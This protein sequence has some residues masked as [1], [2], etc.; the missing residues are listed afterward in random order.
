MVFLPCQSSIHVHVLVVFLRI[1]PAVT[2]LNLYPTYPTADL[3]IPPTVDSMGKPIRSDV[4][5]WGLS[6]RTWNPGFTTPKD[7]VIFL[8]SSMTP[9]FEYLGVWSQLVG[10]TE[11]FLPVSWAGWVTSWPSFFVS[12][13]LRILYQIFQWNMT[14]SWTMMRPDLMLSGGW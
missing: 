4:F 7:V 6:R 12:V 8:T 5:C 2:M 11:I 14:A 9:I 3:F 10:E 1:S 13:D